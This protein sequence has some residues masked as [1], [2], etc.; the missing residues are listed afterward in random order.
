MLILLA[1]FTATTVLGGTSGSVEFT[2]RTKPTK[3]KYAPHNVVAIWVTDSKGNFVKTLEIYGRKRKK[4]LISWTKQS[5]KNEV[6]AVTG[7]TLKKHQT[8]TVAWDCRDNKGN[9]MPDG[10]YQLHVECTNKNGQ[11]PTTPS[12]HIQFKK[13]SRAVSFTPKDL[14]YFDK[15]KLNYTP[16]KKSSASKAK[17]DIKS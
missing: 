6:D 15:M 14:P 12:G 7:A 4:Y 2:V 3:E 1:F 17:N 9:L 8:H 10:N 11:G 13:G 16:Q 5:K